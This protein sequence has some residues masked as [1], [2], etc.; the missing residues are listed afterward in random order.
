VRSEPIWIRVDE[1]GLSAAALAEVRSHVQGVRENEVHWLWAMSAL[2][3]ALQ[4][5]LVG[6]FGTA[7]GLEAM[8]EERA[9]QFLQ[10]M[11]DPSLKYPDP[12][13]E[14][15][16]ALYAYAKRRH[17]WEPGH[18]V[19]DAV[20]RLN[21]LRNDLEHFMPK[22]WSIEAS[23]LPDIT[24]NV[25]SAISDLGWGRAR[26]LPW[27]SEELHDQCRDLVTGI[28]EDLKDL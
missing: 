11:R 28:L 26:A 1:E 3:L 8:P 17:G 25:L 5:F 23:G 27:H 9:E 16:L 13:M 21:D 20:M 2:K 10:A 24:K 4:T 12:K 15:F 6:S 18:D 14:R 19:D 22:A 7:R